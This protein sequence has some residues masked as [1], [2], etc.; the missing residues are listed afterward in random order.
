MIIIIVMLNILMVSCAN[1]NEE[2]DLTTSLAIKIIQYVNIEQDKDEFQI[3]NMGYYIP[4]NQTK[5][6]FEEIYFYINYQI[7]AN[8]AGDIVNNRLIAYYNR[9]E[10]SSIQYFSEEMYEQGYN[11]E[12][13]ERYLV[14]ED[15]GLKEEFD[16][17]TIHYLVDLSE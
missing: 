14:I 6:D 10:N 1:S 5:N 9:E 8:S 2:V 7:Y 4:E 15:T 17:R 12:E 13:Y 3:Y 16:S 11:I